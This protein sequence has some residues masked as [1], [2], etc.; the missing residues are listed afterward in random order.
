M[1]IYKRPL[2]TQRITLPVLRNNAYLFKMAAYATSN[3]FSI[4]HRSSLFKF[5]KV[6]YLFN[7]IVPCCRIAGPYWPVLFKIGN[8]TKKMGISDTTPEAYK[9]QCELY[10]RMSP[11]KKLE[12]V[13]DAYR[14]G[15]LLSMAGIR[16]RYPDADEKEV[17][18]IWA[19]RH[20][21][22]ELYNKVYCEYK[23]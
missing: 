10:R 4:V 17:W 12:L 20:L 3:C 19:K 23:E 8:S 1:E 5:D 21:G 7:D 11:E 14:M 18:H 13:S 15:Q 9:V 22:E 2:L 16:M 6:E